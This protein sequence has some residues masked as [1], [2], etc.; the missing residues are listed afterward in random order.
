[1]SFDIDCTKIM[2]M[3]RIIVGAEGVKLHH[4]LGKLAHQ[5][6]PERIHARCLQDCPADAALAQAII[7]RGNVRWSILIHDLLSQS[8]RPQN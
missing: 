2:L 1:M 7:Q 3:V 4:R 6:F 5:M 8:I